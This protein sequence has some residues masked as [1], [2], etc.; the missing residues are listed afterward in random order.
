MQMKHINSVARKVATRTCS[1]S[2]NDGGVAKSRGVVLLAAAA[3]GAIFSL[4]SLQGCIPAVFVAGAA[5]GVTGSVI[6]HDQRSTKVIMEDRDLTYKAQT[7]IDND[8]DLQ[9]R[10]HISVTTFNYKMLVVGQAVSEELRDHAMKVINTVPDIKMVHNEITIEKP[11]SN[12]TR[13]K[14]SWITTKVKSALLAQKGLHSSQIK[15]LTENGVVYMMGMVTKDH[16]DLAAT[17]ASQVEDV[18]RVVKLFE[19]L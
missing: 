1:T 16:G 13:T 12:S 6:I 14:D 18:T 4:V 5:A 9:V 7:K 15:I 17:A 3:L 8:L 19:Y 2:G 10:T 11:T